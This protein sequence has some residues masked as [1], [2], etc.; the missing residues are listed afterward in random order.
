VRAFLE[1][2]FF[3]YPTDRQAEV[4]ARLRA[5]GPAGEGEAQRDARLDRL[6]PTR[7]TLTAAQ[8]GRP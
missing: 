3:Y 8:G 2:A 4:A 6:K 7:S 1:K 5:D